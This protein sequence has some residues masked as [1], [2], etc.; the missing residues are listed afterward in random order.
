MGT[1]LACPNAHS[2]KKS[3]LGNQ[4]KLCRLAEGSSQ[5]CRMSRYRPHSWLQLGSLRKK[6][7]QHRTWCPPRRLSGSTRGSR[8]S[9]QQGTLCILSLPLHC[10]SLSHTCGAP[11]PP[12]GRSSRAG[13]CCSGA[14]RRDCMCLLS[15]MQSCSSNRRI[16]SQGGI[17]DSC[18]FRRWS[19]S[20]KHRQ[21]MI[22]RC[23]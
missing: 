14:H 3:R 23:S 11:S 7:H 2:G 9:F 20:P 1:P 15:S 8:K 19:M 5:C 21:R 12:R 13:M 4:R 6:L 22:H 10:T 17:Q 16:G 18:S